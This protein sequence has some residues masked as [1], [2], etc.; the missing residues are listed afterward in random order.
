MLTIEISQLWQKTKGKVGLNNNARKRQ[1]FPSGFKAVFAA[2]AAK[3]T[4]RLFEGDCFSVFD[5]PN[6]IE[7]GA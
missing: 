6:A 3:T 1:I 5:F 7:G 4:R 2:V